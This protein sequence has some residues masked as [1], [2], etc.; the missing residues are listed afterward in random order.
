MHQSRKD[1]AESHSQFAIGACLATVGAISCG[2]ILRKGYRFLKGYKNGNIQLTAD[3]TLLR[4]RILFIS[5]Q[6]HPSNAVFIYTNHEDFATKLPH[7]FVS[8]VNDHY[9]MRIYRVKNPEEL[10]NALQKA[11]AEFKA[12][13]N[14]PLHNGKIQLL[15]F[16]GH[17]NSN[18][19][20]L[21]DQYEFRGT[22]NETKSIRQYLTPE[23]QVFLLGCNT[24]TGD[25]SLTKRLSDQLPDAEVAGINSTY[26]SH[27]TTTKTFQGRLIHK[28]YW[29]KNTTVT[30]PISSTY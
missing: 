24:A 20:D 14:N 18:S 7:P 4:H 8:F 6:I 12:L 19:M 27:L 1:D 25:N 26:N 29:P 23:P 3:K 5:K 16:A 30:Y 22:A 17:A 21:D 9:N 11:H 28:H 15:C 13:E 2:T 10:R